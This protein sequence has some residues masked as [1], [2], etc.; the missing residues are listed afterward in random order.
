M[1][2][3]GNANCNGP[4]G[5]GGGGVLWVSQSTLPGNVNPNVDGGTAGSTLASS[6]GNCTVGGSNFATDGGSGSIQTSLNLIQTNC[7][8]TFGSDSLAL[9]AGDSTFLAGEW[10]KE[11]GSYIDSLSRGCCDSIHE[12]HLT[13]L[14]AK[15]G[16]YHDTICSGDTLNINGTSY[17]MDTV[18]AVE[19]FSNVGPYQCDST[20]IIDLKVVMVDTSVTRSGSRLKANATEAIYQWLVCPDY[21]PLDGE[22]SDSL[23]IQD[24]GSYAVLVTQHGCSDTSECYTID[25]IGSVNET[26]VN[27]VVVYPNPTAGIV[28]IDLGSMESEFNVHVTDLTGK[29][30]YRET[31]QNLKGVEFQLNQAPGLYIIHIETNDKNLYVP[32]VLN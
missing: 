5:G 11:S 2:N 24:S 3:V 9:C 27:D 4:G 30:V 16:V 32:V 23:S 13:I 6:Q 7:V 19:I 22:N 31:F 12:T 1:N 14:P 15:T 21:T 26:T 10:Q 25:V 20:V 29:M 8:T 17:T 28:N 18:G